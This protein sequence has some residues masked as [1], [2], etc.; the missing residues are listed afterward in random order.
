LLAV[1]ANIRFIGMVL[2]TRKIYIDAVIVGKRKAITANG[3]ILAKAGLRI[4][5]L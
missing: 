4:T 3:K 1:V 2:D 5:K